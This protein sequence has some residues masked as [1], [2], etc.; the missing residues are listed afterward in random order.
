LKQLY[1]S[2][3]RPNIIEVPPA[4][5]LMITERGEP[6]GGGYQTALRALYSVA[7]RVKSKAKAAGRDF[8]MMPLE[9]LWWW[10]EPADDMS[11]S[12]PREEWNWKSMIRLPDFV[13]RKM[14]EEAKTEVRKGKGLEKADNVV[15]E[16]YNEGL[17]AQILHIGPY[18]EEE[19]T[20]KKLHRF[21][22]ERGYRVRG[23]HHEI[24][25]SDPRRTP[26][27]RWRTIIRQPIERADDEK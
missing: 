23:Y 2:S 9:G 24:Y 8:V 12:P 17:S 10:D 5:F 3:R 14:V 26:P 25:L 16:E 1:S 13:T 18:S 15:L 4:K 21:I 11:R 19:K 27:G 6:G 22:N 20:I 7:Y